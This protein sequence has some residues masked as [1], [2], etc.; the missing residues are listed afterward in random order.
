MYHTEG[1]VIAVGPIGEGDV[2]LSV[3]TRDFGKLTCR[4]QGV[5]KAGSRLRSI[6]QTGALIDFH[7]L[8]LRSGIFRLT[9][10]SLVA[11]YPRGIRR[12]STL[13]V[14]LESI[15]VFNRAVLDGEKDPHLW[16]FMRGWID[17]L[18]DADPTFEEDRAR[19]WFLGNL[20]TVLGHVSE[21]NARYFT[22][23]LPAFSEKNTP[24]AVRSTVSQFFHAYIPYGG[25]AGKKTIQ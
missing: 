15:A 16:A 19:L 17:A 1:I 6:L 22:M 13:P 14:F 5:R 21:E 2:I 9:S 10:P 3:F 20:M 8:P 24:D 18:S 23:P 4:A 25:T 7:F 11:L 12:A